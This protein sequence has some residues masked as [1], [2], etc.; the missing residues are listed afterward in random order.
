MGILQRLS[1]PYLLSMVRFIAVGAGCLCC[2]VLMA[3]KP[4][5]ID[6]SIHLAPA[7]TEAGTK[8]IHEALRAQDPSCRIWPDPPSQ[9]VIVRTT[10]PLDRTAFEQ[11]IA[12][13]GAHVVSVDLLLP[14]GDSERRAMIMASMGFPVFVDTGDPE[15]DQAN[16]QAAKEAWINADPARYEALIRA[17][18]PGQPQEQE[19]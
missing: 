8:F 11:A 7:F 10:V 5:E 1:E 12:P 19:R 16:Y 4:V 15:L 13:G 2:G 18:D 9:R 3:Q 6:Y 17:L 14:A